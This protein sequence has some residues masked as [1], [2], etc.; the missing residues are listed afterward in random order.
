M[1]ATTVPAVA[2][3]AKDCRVFIWNARNEH[4]TDLCGYGHCV[5]D[6][7]VRWTICESHFGRLASVERDRRVCCMMASSRNKL[8]N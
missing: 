1:V 3:A 8:E 2:E 4:E 7:V 5:P 6:G